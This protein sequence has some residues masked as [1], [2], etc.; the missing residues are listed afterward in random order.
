LIFNDGF[1]NIQINKEKYEEVRKEVLNFY[2]QYYIGNLM[3]L[4]IISNKPFD[5]VRSKIETYFN[6]LKENQEE[7]RPLIGPQVI[8][9][10]P[11]ANQT[12]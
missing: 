3:T 11:F 6:P 8:K 2:N 9:I 10:E 7:Q 4:T 12:K 1:A 5:Q